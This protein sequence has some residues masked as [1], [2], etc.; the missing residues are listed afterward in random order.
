MYKNFTK[1]KIVSGKY[2]DEIQN[3]EGSAKSINVAP[4]KKKCK[5]TVKERPDVVKEIEIAKKMSIEYKSIFGK[6]LEIMRS[7]Q[8]QFLVDE[9]RYFK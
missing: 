1:G 8:E 3:F 9:R 7:N 5:R 2:Y 6:Q 4:V